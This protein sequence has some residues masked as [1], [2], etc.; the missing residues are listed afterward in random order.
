[1]EFVVKREKKGKTKFPSCSPGWSA[2]AQ[3][4]LTVT[5]ASRVQRQS[6][7]M[8]VRLVSNSQPQGSA[9]LGLPKCWDYRRE[10]LKIGIF[11]A[12]W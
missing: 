11:K 12:A 3:S 2:V 8:L 1:M 7:S 4:W 5:S 10:P 6:F 9:R